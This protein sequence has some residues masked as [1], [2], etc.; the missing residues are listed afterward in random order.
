MEFSFEGLLIGGFAVAIGLGLT[1]WGFRL[2]LFLLPALGFLGGFLLGAGIVEEILGRAFLADLLGWAVGFGLGLVFAAL[3]YL[4]YWA[5]VGLF[6]GIVGYQ[7]TLGLLAWIGFDE[8][9]AL[10]ILAAIVVGAIFAIGFLVSRMPAVLAIVGTAIVGAGAVVAGLAVGLGLVQRAELADGIFGVYSSQELG[11]LGIVVLAG[12]ALSGMVYQA[13]SIGDDDRS[14]GPAAHRDR[15][16]G[17]PG[18]PA[19]A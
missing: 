18:G 12:L 4:Y 3:S 14:I 10:A 1:L 7:L 5:A 15:G 13:R 9:G 11:W 17:Q 8:S 16:I 2:F 6:G 19:P